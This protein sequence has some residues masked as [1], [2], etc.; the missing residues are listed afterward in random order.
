MWISRARVR[1][2]K[3]RGVIPLCL[4]RFII[5]CRL[6]WEWCKIFVSHVLLIGF[7]WT[8][9]TSDL[10]GLGSIF[11]MYVHVPSQG[12]SVGEPSLAVC[13]FVGA[14]TSPFTFDFLWPI[15][16]FAW[17]FWASIFP[18]FHTRRACSAISTSNCRE[19]EPLSCRGNIGITRAK[20]HS[21][22]KTRRR[23][24]I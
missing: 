15:I 13:A 19:K 6:A 12:L 11:P 23:W 9:R 21:R 17:S 14:P 8:W 2:R 22:L 7:A 18:K 1:W 20:N 24:E 16:F 4:T 3:I 10:L 5:P